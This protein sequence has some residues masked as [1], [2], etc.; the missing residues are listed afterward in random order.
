[1]V[2]V[3]VDESKA[4]ELHEVSWDTDHA[5]FSET[6]CTLLSQRDYLETPLVRPQGNVAGLYAYYNVPS[7]KYVGGLQNIRATRLSMAC[8]LF[9]LRFW[10]DVLLVRSFGGQWENLTIGQIYGACV[11]SPDLRPGMQESLRMQQSQNTT[12]EPISTPEWLANAAQQ[13][14]HDGAA[15]AKVVSAMQVHEVDDDGDSESE[16]DDGDGDDDDS[17]KANNDSIDCCEQ[18]AESDKSAESDPIRSMAPTNEFV[19]KS[20]LCLH[21]RRPCADL[22]PSCKGCYFCVSPRTCQSDGW[23]HECQCSSWK[24][25]ALDHRKQLSTFDGFGKDSW[26]TRLVERAFQIS[27]EPY[28]AFLSE[29][30]IDANTMSWWRT[31]MGGWSGGESSSAST[32]D[33]TLRR[34]YMQGF[35]PI[36]DIPPECRITKEDLDRSGLGRRNELGLLILSSWK[37]YYKLR[38]IPE[39]SPMALLATFPMTI[40]YAIERYGSVP[41]TVARMM[42]RPLR[43]HVVGAEKEMNFLD[44]FKEVGFLLPEDLKVSKYVGHLKSAVHESLSLNKVAC[45]HFFRWKWCL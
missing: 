20:P 14:Y 31:E 35:A 36:R 17:Q 10:G 15:L 24:L 1:M 13:N 38:N 44:L 39:S 2:L 30:G 40:Y 9:S 6:I 8:G 26:P 33:A 3:P 27:E 41:V 19:A 37:E 7:N 23:S 25:Y 34:S 16:D 29:L 43:I 18:K 4:L 5:S 32:V 28:E 42:N 45:C 12:T 22:C 21:C 11:L